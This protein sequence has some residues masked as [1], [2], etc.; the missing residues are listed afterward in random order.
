MIATKSPD[1]PTCLSQMTTL[2]TE[3]EQ[4]K[5]NSASIVDSNNIEYISPPSR[6]ADFIS[7]RA[8]ASGL[9]KTKSRP[10]YFPSHLVRTTYFIHYEVQKY[11]PLGSKWKVVTLAALLSGTAA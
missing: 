8:R 11:P 10:T 3:K 2:Q 7:R 9:G 6:W 5:V 1:A 4:S